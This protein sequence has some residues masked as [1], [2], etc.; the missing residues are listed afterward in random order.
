MALSTV[1]QVAFRG[2]RCRRSYRSLLARRRRAA[3]ILQAAER[4]KRA[5]IAAVE[6]RAQRASLWEQLWD[7]ES[8][9][10][11]YFCK[12]CLVCTWYVPSCFW[13]RQVQE[14]LHWVFFGEAHTKKLGLLLILSVRRV[15]NAPEPRLYGIG[16]HSR[17]VVIY[18]HALCSCSGAIMYSVGPGVGM[19]A[20]VICCRSKDVPAM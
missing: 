15:C 9:C 20:A 14:K 2:F 4:R 6:L 10:Y 17:Y 7:D 8:G 16:T 3:T 19:S 12:V 11:Y 13:S 1:Y 5:L 18:E